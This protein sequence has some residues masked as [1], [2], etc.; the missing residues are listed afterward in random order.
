MDSRQRYL[1]EQLQRRESEAVELRRNLRELGTKFFQLERA[2]EINL[3]SQSRR[4]VEFNRMKLESEELRQLH[5]E[6]MRTR[7]QLNSKLMNAITERDHWKEAFLQQ[8][9]VIK[10][11]KEDCDNAVILVK[12]ECEEILKMTRGKTE[13]QFEDILELY[14]EAKGQVHRLQEQIETYQGAERKYENRTFELANLLETLKR[15]DVDVGSVCQLVAEALKNLTE[16]KNLFEESMKNLRH[17]AWTV[18]DRKD[19]P[20][21]VLLR[22]QNSVLREVVKNLKRK[23]QTFGQKKDEMPERESEGRLAQTLRSIEKRTATIDNNLPKVILE[24]NIV[25]LVNN[26]VNSSCCETTTDQSTNKCE[27]TRENDVEQARS[28]PGENKN[29]NRFKRIN[30]E[31][32]VIDKRGRVLYIESHFSGAVYE[33]YL[34]EMSVNREIKIKYPV[35]LDK[36]EKMINVEFVDSETEYEKSPVDRMLILFKNVYAVV[37]VKQTGVPCSTQTTRIKTNNNFAQTALTGMKS[38]SRLNVGA[39]VSEN[40]FKLLFLV[41]WISNSRAFIKNIAH[42]LFIKSDKNRANSF[43]YILLVALKFNALNQAQTMISRN[44]CL[45][46]DGEIVNCIKVLSQ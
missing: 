40:I 36:S 37:N 19:E 28:I 22:E 10:R 43:S 16:R 35:S 6:A 1:E 26:L 21:L 29:D 2:F 23:L 3:Q 41:P 46:S 15:F 14:N 32:R 25:P 30:M 7:T 20:Q 13:K 11:N 4:E 45:L 5:E 34:I 31:D 18:K 27:K 39:T 24:R 44:S 8:R 9:E 42:P 33:E 38:F 12:Q 17:L